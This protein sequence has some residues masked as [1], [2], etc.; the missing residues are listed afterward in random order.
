[1]KQEKWCHHHHRLKKKWAKSAKLHGRQASLNDGGGEDMNRRHHL[2]RIYT[3]Q[4]R[5]INIPERRQGRDLVIHINREVKPYRLAVRL[6]QRGDAD[7]LARQKPR[8]N[9]QSRQAYTRDED[10]IRPSR[11][12]RRIARRRQRNA[13]ESR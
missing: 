5:I 4:H 7:N 8:A 11:P 10:D 1:M 6:E 9:S 3:T 13:S 2:S 12:G